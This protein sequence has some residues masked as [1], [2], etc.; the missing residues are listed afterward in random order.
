MV[1][2]LELQR[3]SFTKCSK[4][5]EKVLLDLDEVYNLVIV[6]M[7]GKPKIS[8]IDMQSELLTFEKRFNKEFLSPLAQDRGGQSS[9]FSRPSNLYRSCYWA[10]CES[11]CY[12]KYGDKTELFKSKNVLCVSDI[13]KN[14]VS[15]SK[16]EQDNNVN[17]EFH[18]CY[19]FIKE[20]A[21]GR[22]LLN[23]TIKD[24][25]SHLDTVKKEKRAEDLDYSSS[26]KKQS[27]HK[28][29][30][31]STFLLSGGTNLVNSC[32]VVPKTVCHKRLG[33]PS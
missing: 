25:L 10:E 13:T 6:V 18:G 9:N 27:M 17:I 5:P 30:G 4:L 1:F 33:H 23:E 19:Y 2:N 16:L 11:I 22:T 28:N 20:K 31:S 24:G 12:S 15:V 3:I 14:L 8:W 21:T 7:Q 29:K 32:V 26:K